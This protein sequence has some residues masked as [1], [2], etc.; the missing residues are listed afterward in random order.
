MHRLILS[1]L[2]PLCLALPAPARA[3]QGVTIQA[4]KYLP[5]DLTVKAGET[6][7]WTSNDT[8][9]H[10]VTADDGSFDSHP[11]CGQSGGSCLKKNGT[12]SH[13]FTKPGKAAYYCRIHGGTG[14]QGMA[15]TITVTG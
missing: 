11:T 9:G 12:Y 5:R 6:V 13:A 8:I 4:N 15:A 2:L 7:T 3:D 1:T 14:G 10:T